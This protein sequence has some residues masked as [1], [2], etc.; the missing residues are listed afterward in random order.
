MLLDD[1]H[2]LGVLLAE[3]G[4]I[5]AD[6]GEELEADGRHCRGSGPGRDAALE[7]LRQLLDL[8]PGLEA[9]RVHLLGGRGED[10]VDAGLHR[11]APRRRSSVAR[12]A[13]QIL[14]CAELGRVDEE[15]DDDDVVLG[16]GGA[17]SAP[18]GRRGTRPSWGRARSCRR[19]APRLSASR[20][21]PIVAHGPHR[22]ASRSVASA[23]AR[24]SGLEL[25]AGAR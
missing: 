8:D 22:M 1:G 11:R 13:S 23:S 7:A 3:V 5:R 14:A 6:D 16:A 21:S 12:V 24:Y 10:E 17:G 20:S 25:R 19:L 15:A 4:A 2:L 18:G 9:L